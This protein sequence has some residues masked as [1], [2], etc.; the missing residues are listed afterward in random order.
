MRKD[1]MSQPVLGLLYRLSERN[2]TKSVYSEIDGK[3]YSFYDIWH[4]HTSCYS[5]GRI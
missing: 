3:S 2:Q 5:T 1:F 4:M